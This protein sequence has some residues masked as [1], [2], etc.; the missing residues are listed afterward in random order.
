MKPAVIFDQDGTLW[1]ARR[2]I[3][4]TWKATFD[5][6]PEITVDADFE[7]M[8]SLLGK[9]IDEIAEILM[10]GVPLD[11]RDAIIEEA[12]E[13]EDSYLWKYGAILYDRLEETLRILRED[14]DLFIVSN[15]QDGYIQ[16]FFNSHKLDY[17]FKDI[18]MFGRT[19]LSKGENI[20]LIMERNGVE[21][22]VYVG[23]TEG[24]ERSARYAGIPFVYCS[25]GFGHAK[26]PDASVRSFAELPETLAKILK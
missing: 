25:Y 5:R 4:D 26:A 21:K 24:D 19:K 12:C 17:L 6:H 2:V 15:S 10:P 8:T 18:E 23:D 22:A 1:D 20:R 13:E 3:Y 7:Y 14:Y 9:T 16:A 11:K